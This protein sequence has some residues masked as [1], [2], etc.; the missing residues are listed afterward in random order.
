[1]LHMHDLYWSQNIVFVIL[2]LE[3]LM[4]SRQLLNQD[5]LEIRL[6]LM[7]GF[8]IGYQKYLRALSK[9]HSFVNKQLSCC[10]LLP[11]HVKITGSIF[12]KLVADGIV[13]QHMPLR[14]HVNISPLNGRTSSYFK[15]AIQIQVTSTDDWI[16]KSRVGRKLFLTREASVVWAGR[17]S[18]GDLA[19]YWR[20]HT[21]TPLPTSLWNHS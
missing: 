5:I 21:V 10:C 8:W 17:S 20:S 7:R 11:Y 15:F 3:L 16:C 19:I 2:G 14:M 12:T 9:H 13:V 6:V 1:M 4:I 18:T